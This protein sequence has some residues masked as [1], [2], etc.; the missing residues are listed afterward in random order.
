MVNLSDNTK[1]TT[2]VTGVGD[3]PTHIALN[4]SDNTALVASPTNDSIYSAP[5]GFVNHL[6]FAF[7]TEALRSNLGITNIGSAEANIQIQLRDN[8]GNLMASGA[9]KV[10]AKWSETT[11]QH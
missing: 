1:F 10:S 9:T 8:D 11:Q 2:V 6:P 7:D 5:L 4:P 3:T